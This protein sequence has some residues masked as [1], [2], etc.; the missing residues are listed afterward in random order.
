MA[1]RTR[2]ARTGDLAI[3]YQ[4]VGDGPDDLVIAPGFI[5][6]LDWSWQEP[7]LRRFLERLAG[8][9]RL[10]LFDKRGTGLSD[11][12]PGPASLEERVEDLAAVMDAAG[13]DRAAVF[14]VSEGG[15][16]AMLFAAQHPERTRALVL[17][18]AYPRV[19]RSA[20]FPCGVEEPVMTAMLSGL[21][22][23]WGEGAGL[24]AWG[25]TRRGDTA[26]RAWWGTLQRL[27]ASPGMARRMFEL[28]PHIDLR[29][30]L[31]AI[32]VPT[33]VMHRRG[34]RM[35]PFGIGQY[36]AEHIPGARLVELQGED[37]LF[38]LGDTETLLAETEEFLTGARPATS[39]GTTV[40]ATVLFVD[41]VGSTELAARVGDAAWASIRDQFLALA[42]DE[43]ARYGGH[44]VDVA[45]DGLF[46]TFEGPARAI[47]CAVAVRG[48][49]ATA[50]LA[51]RAG[52]HAGEVERADG[53]GVSGL[54][55]HIGARVMAEAVPGEVLVSGTVKDLVVG[56]GLGFRDR[57]VRSLRGV[58]GSWPLFAVAG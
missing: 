2:Y 50:G 10:I 15:A 19:T 7:S 17:Y 18:G 24:G 28:Y 13:S 12:V 25:P 38:F 43:L 48:A 55:V 27:G 14:G 8:F 33:L 5:S 46:A 39:L 47:R 3:A 45:G 16:M 32:R 31:P 6:H 21:V 42:R 57:G 40:L 9:S 51:I 37:H 56:S 4:V 11:P 49:A 44:E 22:D 1:P 35:I 23:R 52:V 41:L 26:L 30:V 20:D 29:D 36:L 34:D 54:A 58:P 53:G